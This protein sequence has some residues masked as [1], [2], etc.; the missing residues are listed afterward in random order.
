[1][2]NGQKLYEAYRA[3]YFIP[4]PAWSALPQDLKSIWEATATQFLS[5]V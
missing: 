5:E 4:L 2:T 1:M 3:R